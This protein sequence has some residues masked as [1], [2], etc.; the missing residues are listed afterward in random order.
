MTDV[1]KLRNRVVSERNN[2]LDVRSQLDRRREEREA[3]SAKYTELADARERQLAG[4][5]RSARST[6]RRLTTLQ[7]DESR[8]N[9]LLAALERARRDEA[10]RG[11]C[12]AV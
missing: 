5:Q 7:K 1:E 12:G 8:L 3:E 2:I 10:A 9:G 6:E 11:A 4:L